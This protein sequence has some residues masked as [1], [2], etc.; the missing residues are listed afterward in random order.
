[1]TVGDTMWRRSKALKT[2]LLLVSL[3]H[4]N[5]RKGGMAAMKNIGSY[6]LAVSD[7][8]KKVMTVKLLLPQITLSYHHRGGGQTSKPNLLPSVRAKRLK[9]ITP[10]QKKP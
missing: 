8:P 10:T 4:C 1:M 7:L 3:Q 2:S 6:S 5:A 9:V